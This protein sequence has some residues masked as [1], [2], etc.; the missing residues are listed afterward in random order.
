[1]GGR[2]KSILFGIL[3]L[4]ACSSFADCVIFESIFDELP[5]GWHNNRWTF[6]NPGAKAQHYSAGENWDADL[7][8][9]LGAPQVYYFVPDGADSVVVH[10]VH[11]LSAATDEGGAGGQFWISSTTIG[12]GL[13]YDEYV[14]WYS[15]IT[16]SDPI[17]YSIID[18][19]DGT[20]IG[21]YFYA[22]ASAASYEWASVNWKIH[23]IVVTAYGS[24]MELQSGTWAGIKSAF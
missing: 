15:S 14:F 8:S 16:D 23:S 20:Y 4:F 10:I 18:P 7:S 3:V 21:F 13:I 24:A 6:N 11:V 1:M 2:M 19:P 17:V 5:S 12:G 22:Y 9:Y